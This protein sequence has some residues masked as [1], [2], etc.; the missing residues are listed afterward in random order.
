M[1]KVRVQ[2]I[3][4]IEAA[5]EAEH[6][7][8]AREILQRAERLSGEPFDELIRRIDEVESL[9][10]AAQAGDLVARARTEMAEAN[11]EAA[12]HSLRRA[13]ALDPSDGEICHFLDRAER[14][15]GRQR[16]EL[17]RS[18]AVSDVCRVIE[19]LLESRDFSRA[20]QELH[21]AGVEF[22][23]QPTLIALEA[24]L[25]ELEDGFRQTQIRRGLEQARISFE[26]QDW[27]GAS[28]AADVVLRLDPAHRG[29]SELQEQARVH[30][31]RQEG[32][33]QRREA[34]ESVQEDVERLIAARELGQAASRL[35]D[36]RES[37]G[38]EL[39]FDELRHRIDR[40]RSDLQF[41][42]RIEWAERRAKE[43]ERLIQEASSFSLKGEYS[44]A[45]ES[46]EAARE[47]DPS[48]PDLAD[49]LAAADSALEKHLERKRRSEALGAHE[50]RIGALLDQVRLEEAERA[51]ADAEQELGSVDGLGRL[52][53]RL[54]RMREAKQGS[55]L[56]S[57]GGIRHITSQDL[58]DRDVLTAL[59]QQ[60]VLWKSYP[61][62]Q[63]L[64]FPFRGLGGPV[65]VSMLGLGALLDF[66]VWMGAPSILWFL[67]SL[68]AVGFVPAIVRVTLEGK[69]QL[70]EFQDLGNGRSWL[71]DWPRMLTL[72]CSL[73]G[74]L[75]LWV[76]LREFH[77][78]MTD[79]SG[80]SGWL[81]A[82]ALL[83]LAC[84][85]GVLS[86]G[87]GELFGGEFMLRLKGHL[88]FLGSSSLAPHLVI[89][90]PF[91][92]LVLGFL[93]RWVLLPEIPWLG[94]LLSRGFE[95][96]ALLA[97][98]HAVG[99]L[100]RSRSLGLARSYGL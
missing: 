73:G 58:K 15:L 71:R 94:S 41:R 93:A 22:G 50:Q 98:P 49:L 68:V 67:L 70:L 92:L 75:F 45:I 5:I 91:G 20:R 96:Y 30:L 38:H 14:A 97:V 4:E 85:I 86:L 27:R 48:H 52:R 31:E 16:A 84:A 3:R 2:W 82:T 88:R 54:G 83:W 40:A 26:A 43:A 8:E 80:P 81:L 61:W 62:N 17:E 1:T 46:L 33:K 99:T 95:A 34:L 23:R 77:G 72:V 32:Q 6:Y 35:R 90:L 57:N 76:V 87:V 21:D 69:N 18:H 100:A 89:A 39:V 25:D 78:S 44:S 36:A 9:T 56:L 63:V 65:L 74:P 66:L 55:R 47:L 11:Y 10:R 19:G 37:L 59:S 51:L 12:I 29:A 42:Q 7:T 13:V 24:R 79:V 28:R 60:E 53:G 64:L